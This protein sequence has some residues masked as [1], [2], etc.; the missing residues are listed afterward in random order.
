MR[1]GTSLPSANPVCVRILTTTFDPFATS[2]ICLPHVTHSSANLT[3]LG[4]IVDVQ[5]CSRKDLRVV[6]QETGPEVSWL[7]D[8]DFDI[9]R[10]ELGAQRLRDS[11]TSPFRTSVESIARASVPRSEAA[12]V[13]DRLLAWRCAEVRNESFADVEHAEDV[14][15]EGVVVFLGSWHDQ[16]Q[17]SI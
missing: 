14:R 4:L 5:A 16:S 1:N 17:S 12:K 8:S 15:V 7:D 9:E 6:V 13:R 3:D 11:R 2:P 10:L